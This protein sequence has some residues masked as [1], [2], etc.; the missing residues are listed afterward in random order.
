MV[1]IGCGAYYSWKWKKIWKSVQVVFTCDIAVCAKV[2]GQCTGVTVSI[3]NFSGRKNRWILVN[4]VCANYPGNNFRWKFAR[5]LI[6]SWN[7][8]AFSQLDD[9]Q[10]FGNR[11]KTTKFLFSRLI[12]RKPVPRP[13]SQRLTVEDRLDRDPELRHRHPNR[14]RWSLTEWTIRLFIP[15]STLHVNNNF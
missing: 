1:W 2:D 6:S 10:V 14:P 13:P 15:Y 3:L 12:A 9:K 4:Y 11:V 7:S 8:F 5:V